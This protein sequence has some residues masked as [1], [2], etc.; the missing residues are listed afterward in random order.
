VAEETPKASSLAEMRVAHWTLEQALTIGLGNWIVTAILV[1]Y[2]T[3]PGWGV[4]LGVFGLVETIA[5]V[6]YFRRRNEAALDQAR[7]DGVPELPFS[8]DVP[9]NPT[10]TRYWLPAL[11]TWV[12]VLLFVLLT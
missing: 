8:G 11:A 9:E 12:A 6:S 4:A 1:A 2:F 5:I 7:R 10:A 3:A